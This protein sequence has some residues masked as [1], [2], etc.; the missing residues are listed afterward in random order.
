MFKSQKDLAFELLFYSQIFDS[1]FQYVV[2]DVD[3][4][5]LFSLNHIYFLLKPG[6]RTLQ[7]PIIMKT[8]TGIGVLV[9]AYDEVFWKFSIGSKLVFGLFSI[10]PTVI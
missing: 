1:L 2:C 10:N 9:R 7:N 8:K 4:Y 3:T 6:T 5:C